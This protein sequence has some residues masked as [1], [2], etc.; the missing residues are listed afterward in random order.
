MIKELENKIREALP[1]LKMLGEGAIIYRP[2]WNMF[3]TS[4]QKTCIYLT[5]D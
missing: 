5:M 4:T 1:H 2:H 3:S